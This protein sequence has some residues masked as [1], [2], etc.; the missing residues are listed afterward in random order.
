MSKKICVCVQARLSSKRLSEK[1][2][3]GIHSTINLQ[4]KTIFSPDTV[5][6]DDINFKM[7]E[8]ITEKSQ[9]SISR[10]WPSKKDKELNLN[11]CG[12]RSKTKMNDFIFLHKKISEKLFI[13]NSFGIESNG[14]TTCIQIVKYV[15]K[16]N[17]KVIKL[18]K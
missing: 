14:L 3:L 9:S 18:K 8:G 7:T 1:D 12:I 2:G 15:K 11:Y 13:L 6:V 10:Y 16:N 17:R 4:G 5:N